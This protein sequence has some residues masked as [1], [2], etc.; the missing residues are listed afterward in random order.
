MQESN[1]K[2]ISSYNNGRSKHKRYSSH[3]S[4][5]LVDKFDQRSVYSTTSGETSSRR[6][7]TV[8]NRKKTQNRYFGVF[9]RKKTNQERYK[10]EIDEKYAA[11]DAAHRFSDFDIGIGTRGDG[12]R[13]KRGNDENTTGMSVDESPG[14]GDDGNGSKFDGLEKS[15]GFLRSSF[16]KNGKTQRQYVPGSSNSIKLFLNAFRRK[17]DSTDGRKKRNN[18]IESVGF[19]GN[20]KQSAVSSP[21][22]VDCG[23]RQEMDIEVSG[24]QSKL[25]ENGQRVD[26]MDGGS[27]TENTRDGL[28]PLRMY[29]GQL[30]TRYMGSDGRYISDVCVPSTLDEHTQL[31]RELETGLGKC[32]QR[33]RDQF[34]IISFHGDHVHVA[35]VCPYSNS[36]CRCSWIQRS[37]LWRKYKRNRHRR[38][39]YVA[40]LSLQQW[41]DILGYFTTAGHTVENVEG[42]SQDGRFCIRPQDLQVNKIYYL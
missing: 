42:G 7:E 30:Y 24:I 2:N 4:R 15:S 8:R 10:E 17:M 40:N 38:R 31:L 9:R 35:H 39:V 12:R 6:E 26:C 20:G 1:I 14:N 21:V 25:G 11:D 41:E 34:K 32:D 23:T 19:D 29:A 27:I 3:G 18:V 28:D 37:P 16:S 5:Q 36:S 13:S 33:T 22:D